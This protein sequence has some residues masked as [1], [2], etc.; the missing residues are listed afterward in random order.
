M[1]GE[2]PL[3][4]LSSQVFLVYAKSDMPIGFATMNPKLAY[5]WLI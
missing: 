3:V 2:T 1:L 5:A 4:L